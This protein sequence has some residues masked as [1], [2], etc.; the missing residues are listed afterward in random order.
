MGHRL[1]RQTWVQDWP[2]RQASSMHDPM[3]GIPEINTPRGVKW[4]GRGVRPWRVP[5]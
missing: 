1:V 5:R 3:A 4:L 2:Q